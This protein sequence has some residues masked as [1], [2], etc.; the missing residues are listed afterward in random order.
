MLLYGLRCIAVFA[1]LVIGR[2][3][4]ISFFGILYTVFRL[5]ELRRCPRTLLG[6]VSWHNCWVNAGI[7][8]A[9]CPY[10]RVVISFANTKGRIKAHDICTYF[11][12]KK[13]PSRYWRSHFLFCKDIIKR[14]LDNLGLTNIL[15]IKTK[16][17]YNSFKK[18]WSDS[19]SNF[20]FPQ[21]MSF[22]PDF[23]RSPK[24]KRLIHYQMFMIVGRI[25][26]DQI[27][28]SQFS[29]LLNYLVGLWNENYFNDLTSSSR[30]NL[31][32]YN[33]S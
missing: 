23:K 32:L 27:L 2:K 25:K 26:K 6:W 20:D 11:Q 30:W 3:S 17:Y 15:F 22:K 24:P 28:V 19:N 1:S 9:F 18:K 4:F 31:E 14:H 7:V 29:I 8:V 5:M 33:F 16:Y 13:L 10:V 12:N 21:L